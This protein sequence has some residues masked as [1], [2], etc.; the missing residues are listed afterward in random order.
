MVATDVVPLV[1]T[2]PGVL[3][4]V[5]V[6]VA[7]NADGPVITGFAF[8]VTVFVIEQPVDGNV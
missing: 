7:H 4:W 1:H 2:P 6:A 8:T 5:M 3:D